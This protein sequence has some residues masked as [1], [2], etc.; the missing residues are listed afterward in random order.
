MNK[1]VLT[2]LAVV[3][4]LAVLPVMA[5]AEDV[6]SAAPVAAEQP[7]A[8]DHGAVA[9]PTDHGAVSEHGVEGEEALVEGHEEGAAEG[10]HHAVGLPQMD[11]SWFPSQVFWLALTFFVLYTVFGKKLLPDISSTLENRRNHIQGDLDSAQDLREEVEKVQQANEEA[12]AEARANATK[13]FA[14]TQDSLQRKAQKKMD[15]F[16][17]SSQKK[18]KEVE[19]SIEEEKAQAMIEMQTIAAEIASSA[20]EKIIGVSTDIDQAKNLVKNIGRK[21]A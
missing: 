3:I 21:A 15:S 16:A 19:A 12:L 4:A 18:T 17:A 2:F 1:T 13:I 9:A 20:A 10:G 6:P 8:A 11:T 14:D 7:A 5:I